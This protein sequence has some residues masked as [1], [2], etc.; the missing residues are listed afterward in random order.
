MREITSLTN[1]ALKKNPIIYTV[2]IEHRHDGFVIAVQD[3]QEDDRSKNAIADDLEYA[4]KLL[5]NNKD[6]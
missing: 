1:A 3:I 2:R 5:R 4:A 6:K